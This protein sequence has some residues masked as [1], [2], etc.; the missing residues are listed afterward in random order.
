L[1]G[2]VVLDEKTYEYISLDNFKQ[3]IDEGEKITVRINTIRD[4]EVYSETIQ[5]ITRENLNE[6]KKFKKIK[7]K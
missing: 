2:N 5:T 3:K 1:N 4:G 7:F 6:L